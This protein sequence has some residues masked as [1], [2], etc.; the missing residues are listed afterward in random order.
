MALPA[1]CWR[2]V[3]GY[4]GLYQVSTRGRVRSVGRWVNSKNGSKQFIKGRIMKP[5]RLNGY[6]FVNL[7]RN[8][9]K[10]RFSVHRLVAMAWLDNPE[11]KPEVNHLDENPGNPDVF[12]LSW[13][14]AKENANWGTRNKRSADSR[15]KTVQALDTETGFV[16]MEFPSTAEARRN[17]FNQACISEC[18]Q[19][20][21]RIHKGFFWRYKES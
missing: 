18:C 10:R 9:K 17:G 4:V 21:R 19:G 15:S 8:G 20:K 16:V 7:S 12:N 3:P 14:S 13:A 6:L 2:W 1:E 11:G 5:A